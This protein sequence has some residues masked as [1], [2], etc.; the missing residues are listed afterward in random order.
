MAPTPLYRL[1]SGITSLAEPL[2]YAHVARK[3]RAQGVSEERIRERRG[4]ASQPR[5]EGPVLWFHGA[6]VGE[7]LSVLSLIARLGQQAPD[8]NFLMTSGTAAS[9][10]I[11]AKRLPPRTRHQF[12][13][14]DSPSVVA[15]F[16]DHWRPQSAIFVESELWPGLLVLSKDKGV[17]LALLNA[18]LSEKSAN[19]WAK[20]PKTARMVLDC[21]DIMLTQN[22]EIAD[23]LRR[24]GADDARLRVGA[25][26]KASAAPLPVDTATADTIGAAIGGRP[27]WATSSTHPGEEELAIA[28]H[29]QILTT[30]PDALMILI[31]RHPDRADAVAALIN[32]SGLRCA[33]RSAGEPLETDTQVYLADT[34][35][36][37]GTWY[38]LSPVVLLGGSLLPD[39]G[40]HNPFEPA[41][42]GAAVLTGPYVPNFSETFPP[43]IAA[44]AACEVATSDDIA[45]IVTGWLSD[46]E[47]CD[48]ARDAAR[49]FATGQAA[50]LDEVVD[51]LID[52]LDLAS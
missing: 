5:P 24:M 20:W 25:N 22:A 9:A 48:R 45:R 18:R 43:M 23:R 33:R 27:V 10:E 26:L 19:G 28:A 29:R 17:R 6:S 31:P 41:Q 30:F 2:V 8:L 46:P 38:A 36:E 44:G 13:P 7:S 15:R 1:Y 34:L 37:T 42:S 49:S 14:L 39:I 12:A 32:A 11:I 16:L 40:G 52:T 47:S 50:A 51:T 21:F 3:L 4:V 35:G